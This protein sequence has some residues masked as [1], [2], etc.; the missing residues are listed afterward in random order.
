MSLF[1]KDQEG[2]HDNFLSITAYPDITVHD[3]SEDHEFILLACDGKY[4]HVFHS[5]NNV[6]K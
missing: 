1:L 6:T 2:V 4:T 3:V 5:L